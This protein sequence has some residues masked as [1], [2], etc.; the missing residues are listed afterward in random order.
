IRETVRRLVETEETA[1]GPLGE[2]LS[3]EA[4]ERITKSLGNP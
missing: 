3:E 2:T 4:K 1:G